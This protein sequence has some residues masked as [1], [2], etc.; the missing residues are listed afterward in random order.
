MSVLEPT[1]EENLIV[2]VFLRN[3]LKSLNP[4]LAAPSCKQFMKH[5][6]RS[7][8][9]VSTFALS[10]TRPFEKKASVKVPPVSIPTVNFNSNQHSGLGLR[11]SF[12]SNNK[13][14]KVSF[15]T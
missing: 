4:S 6:V 8:G 13:K 5:T 3:S 2:S 10:V 15:E 14:K 7:C 1:V 12:P 9:V 11:V